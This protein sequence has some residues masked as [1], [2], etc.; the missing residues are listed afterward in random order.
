[1]KRPIAASL[2]ACAVW[3][4]PARSEPADLS[5]NY[6]MPGCRH[7]VA[8]GPGRI[9][10]NARNAQTVYTGGWCAGFVTGIALVNPGSC[11]PAGSTIDQTLRV[12][13]KYVDERPQRM[14]EDFSVLVQEALATTWPCQR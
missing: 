8:V 9:A 14:H 10:M 3:S 4:M 7:I 5:A 1:M 12:V 2:A 13:V 11:P 6:L